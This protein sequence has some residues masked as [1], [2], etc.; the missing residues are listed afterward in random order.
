MFCK[1]IVDVVVI[2]VSV[3]MTTYQ[4]AKSLWVQ[5]SLKVAQVEPIDDHVDIILEE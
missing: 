3:K 5:D 4:T 2:A 1:P